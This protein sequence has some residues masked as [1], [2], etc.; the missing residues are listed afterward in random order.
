MN[1]H[2]R[3]K[4][5]IK[6]TT[7]QPAKVDVKGWF[8][9]TIVWLRD[10][11]V[12]RANRPPRARPTRSETIAERVAERETITTILL[13]VASAGTVMLTYF[14]VAGPM[15]EQGAGLIQKGEALAF[16]VV[17]GIFSWLGWHYLFG[18]APQ[19]KGAR[20]AAAIAAAA[21]YIGGIA[22][23]DAQ[24]N[25]L[26]LGG[27]HAVQLSLADTTRAYEAMRAA[28]T[29]RALAI[30]RIVPSIRAQAQRFSN[31]EEAE[32]KTGAQS[33]K[34]GAG[35]VS[36]G[37]GQ[38][39]T[40][41]ATL[42]DQLDAGMA[43]TNAIQAAMTDEI[44]RMK[45][46]T[47]AQG[48]VRARIATVSASADRLDD[49]FAQ[50]TQYDYGVSIKATLGSI[51]DIFPVATDARSKFEATQNA[52]LAQIA[53]MAKPVAATLG[54]ALDELS[55]RS[56]ASAA[57]VRPADPASAIKLYWRE[58]L[59]Q[60][61]AAVFVNFAPAILL[62]ILLAGRR[63]AERFGTLDGASL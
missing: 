37:F 44:G 12:A 15:S 61:I 30:R 6:V 20:L 45:Q 55:S 38:I 60:W 62:V 9:A 50:L 34:K 32:I 22:G 26:A 29:Q 21:L 49:Q 27:D 35:K 54:A 63:E 28:G 48:P 59:P 18:L 25:M 7:V 17:I 33:G 23:V 3:P 56:A 57:P 47:Y 31:L 39:A 11:V 46:A 41:L 24:F 51:A 53:A 40:L 2:Y 4:R 16:A 10:R 43:E 1:E 36:Q 42:G 8:E 52:E 14:G 5:S 19:L 58:L 13:T